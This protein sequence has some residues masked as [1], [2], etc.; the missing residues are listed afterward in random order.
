[1]LT[2][3][4]TVRSCAGDTADSYGSPT[5]EHPEQSH[6]EFEFAAAGAAGVPRLVFL[7]SESTDG[8]AGLF[9]DREFGDRQ[10]AFRERLLA[11]NLVAAKVASPPDLETAVLHA[12]TAMPHRE[13]A[14][15]YRVA[16]QDSRGVQIGDGNTQINDFRPR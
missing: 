13:A 6:T 16:V 5:R 1:M 3:G 4:W 15:K 9:L 14:A 10:H 11:E 2:T 8:P 7:L 12:L